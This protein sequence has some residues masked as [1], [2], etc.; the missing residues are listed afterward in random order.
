M[1]PSCFHLH[2]PIGS[3]LSTTLVGV[4]KPEHIVMFGAGKQIEAHINLFLKHYPSLS[5]CTIVNRTLNERARTLHESAAAAFTRV[6]FQLLSRQNEDAIQKA[7]QSANIII[8]ATSA[9]SPLF[10]S[11]WV[12]SGTH[13]I[14]IGSYKPHMQEVEETLVH[15]AIPSV[16]S[17]F[18]QRINQALIV[19]SREACAVEAG[20]L[21][22]AGVEQGSIVEIGELLL[23][24][25]DGRGISPHGARTA[26]ALPTNPDACTGPITIFKSVGIGLQDVII[27]KEVVSHA[28]NMS[29]VGTLVEGYDAA[30]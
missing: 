28:K 17:N 20:D 19:D 11:S 30:I 10:P 23:Q 5:S 22:K 9:T 25:K 6:T 21:I 12:S 8:C 13:V 14:L 15:R 18:D 24:D 16:R 29:G 2:H 7:V 26:S 3:L 4:D 1:N 27:A